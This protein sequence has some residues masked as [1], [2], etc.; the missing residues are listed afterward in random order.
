MSSHRYEIK[1]QNFQKLNTK[2]LYISMSEYQGDWNSIPHTHN[3][4]EL[5]YVIKGKGTFYIDRKTYP[6][7]SNDLVIISPN[8]EH[9]EQSYNATPLEYIVLGIEGIAFMDSESDNSKIIYNYSQKAELLNLLNLL[10]EEVEAEQS[11]YNL[12]CQHLLQ[13]LLIQIIRS[14]KLVP[15]MI[16]SVK[17][18]KECGL[19]KRYLDS[20][21]SENITLDSLADRAHVNKY[22]LVHAFTKYT[23]LS[24]INY[25]SKKRIQAGRELLISTDHSISQI[26]QCLGFSSQSYFSQV[27]RKETN[28]TPNEYRKTKATEQNDEES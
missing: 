23:G 15:V 4:S 26:A 17:M 24:P 3:F 6:I 8:T 14:Q 25:L 18:T 13:V 11:G 27:F 19:I 12:V 2:L 5:F 16:N 20:N 22:Y 7:S 28:M 10:L 1:S 9:T 21:Y